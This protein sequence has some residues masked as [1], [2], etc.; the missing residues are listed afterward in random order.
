MGIPVNRFFV[1]SDKFTGTVS[2]PNPLSTCGL[3]VLKIARVRLMTAN[4]RALQYS[5]GH[6]NIDLISRTIDT[7]RR[8]TVRQLDM[9]RQMLPPASTP[10][11]A[12]VTPLIDVRL[13]LTYLFQ[14]GIKAHLVH[15]ATNK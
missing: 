7:D 6:S 12:T 9:E 10:K 5:T 4:T 2:L 8:L 13:Q 1:K 11:H 3:N 15:Q 14:D